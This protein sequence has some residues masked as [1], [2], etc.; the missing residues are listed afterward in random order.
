MLVNFKLVH[1]I[2]SLFIKLIIIAFST[3]TKNK[4][5]NQEIKNKTKIFF[6]GLFYF[7]I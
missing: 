6:F 5:Q 4:S 2:I 7:Q 3:T 1:Y